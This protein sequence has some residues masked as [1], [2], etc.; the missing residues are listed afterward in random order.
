MSEP[1]DELYFRWLG[2]LV[3]D[4]KITNPRDT[5]WRLLKLLYDKEFVWFVPHDGNRGEDG[6]DLRFEFIDSEG[7][8]D[9][10]HGWMN[11]GCSMLEMLIALSRKLAFNA[12]GEPSGWFWRMIE[13]VGLIGFKDRK[14]Y[15]D[16]A[17][18]DVLERLIWRGYD[19]SGDGGLFPLR[20]A[21]RD[22][23]SIELWY[24]MSA[25]VSENI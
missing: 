9:V 7:L 23:R 20:C 19:Y 14:R 18:D 8:Q 3:A 5:H 21:D 15:A 10:D 22:Q 11:L 12:E 25:Y 4:P 1:L 16:E 24:Q 6:K 2:C 17:V 13:N